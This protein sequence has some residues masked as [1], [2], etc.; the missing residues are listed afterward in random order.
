MAAP[1]K[2]ADKENIEYWMEKGME[3]LNKV[4]LFIYII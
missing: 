1:A 2:L 4:K 3:E